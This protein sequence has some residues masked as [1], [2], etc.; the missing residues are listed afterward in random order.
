ME[1]EGTFLRIKQYGIKVRN[2]TIRG[3]INRLG[4]ID[5]K[6]LKNS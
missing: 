4:T 2:G 5:N 1:R 3:Q 6:L